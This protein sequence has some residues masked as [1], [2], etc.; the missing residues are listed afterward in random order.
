MIQTFSAV[1]VP[2]LGRAFLCENRV[3][4]IGR[5][6]RLDDRRFRCAV[7]LADE[8]L[9]ALRRDREQV[10][11]ARAAIDDVAGAAC[12]LDGGREHRVHGGVRRERDRGD[13]G[14]AGTSVF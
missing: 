3:V 11:I 10:E 6:Q 14:R 5:E 12:R 1:G 13:E 2:A 8:V 4:R 7:H 9:R